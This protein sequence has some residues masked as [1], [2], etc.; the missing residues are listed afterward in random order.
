M[1]VDNGLVL[2]DLQLSLSSADKQFNHRKVF[3]VDVGVLAK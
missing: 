3:L 1:Q 2:V